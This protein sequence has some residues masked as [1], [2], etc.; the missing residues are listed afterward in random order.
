MPPEDEQGADVLP[1]VCQ[2]GAVGT[3]HPLRLQKRVEVHL[4]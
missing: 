2:E 4:G 3:A 1:L